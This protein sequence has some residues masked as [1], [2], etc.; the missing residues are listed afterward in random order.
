LLDAEKALSKYGAEVETIATDAP[1][2]AGRL[3]VCAVAQ[4]AD[5]IVVA[6]GDGTINEVTE[7]MAGTDVPL[8]I[9]P[10]GTANVLASEMRVSTHLGQAA[11]ELL[12][13]PAE[14]IS[15]G[16]IQS[17][18]GEPRSFL[19]M[20]GAGLDAHIVYSLNYSLKRKLGKVAYWL[21]GFS[22]FGRTFEEFSVRIDG[23]EFQSSFALISKVRN[24]GGDLEIAQQ[25]SLLD[26]EFEVVLFHGRESWRYLKYLA[27]V[28]IRRHIG[29][30]GIT[31]LRTR[32]VEMSQASTD[33]VFV[34]VDGEFA[35]HLPARV[36]I[37][38]SSLT[39]L[40]PPHYAKAHPRRTVGALA[41]P[42]PGRHAHWPNLLLTAGKEASTLPE[43]SE[44]TQIS[45]VP[46]LAMPTQLR[47]NAFRSCL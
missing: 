34:Q 14:R 28:A 46:I 5:L 27:A 41:E 20:A 44:P 4:G 10:A 29:I 12:S 19:L 36:E 18:D 35:G 1:R 9:L 3:A 21:A 26:D 15:T 13:Y 2:S 43:C 42:N 32:V 17:R 7:G 37:V 25:V 47:P 45:C 40:V 22:Q 39:L 8:A 6:G 30:K 11:E 33:R 16:R 38:P 24:Y 31:V 23:R